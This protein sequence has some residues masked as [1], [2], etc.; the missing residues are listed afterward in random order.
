MHSLV[1]RYFVGCAIPTYL[2]FQQLFCN[3]GG[4]CTKSI[5]M[6]T[7]GPHGVG[8]APGACL[9]GLPVLYFWQHIQVWH[10][11]SMIA[12]KPGAYHV[13]NTIS[14]IPLL[15][16][17]PLLCVKWASNGSNA[18]GATISPFLEGPSFVVFIKNAF[19]LLPFVFFLLAQCVL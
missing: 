15:L 17:W 10:K 4:I 5:C 18:F 12:V 14:C 3:C 11:F 2:T 13:L 9:A 1:C 16:A 6:Y 7:K 8:C 19:Q